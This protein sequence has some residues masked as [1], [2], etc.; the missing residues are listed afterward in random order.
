MVDPTPT[1][2]IIYITGFIIFLVFTVIGFKLKEAGIVLVAGIIGV[3]FGLWLIFTYA[4]GM[5]GL[6]VIGP[7]LLVALLGGL[8]LYYDNT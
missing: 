3:V 2:D 8:N 1:Q 4:D 7:A 5:I 6:M